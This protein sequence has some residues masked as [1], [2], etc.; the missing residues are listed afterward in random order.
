M[1]WFNLLAVEGTL[2]SLLQLHSSKAYLYVIFLGGGVNK[3]WVHF[4]RVDDINLEQ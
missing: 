1:D 3:T 2:K 4:Q